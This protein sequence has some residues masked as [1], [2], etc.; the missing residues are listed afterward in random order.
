MIEEPWYE[1]V[2]DLD[3][4]RRRVSFS[5]AKAA[6]LNDVALAVSDLTT[7]GEAKPLLDLLYVI[8]ALVG[9]YDFAFTCDP[10]DF[11]PTLTIGGDDRTATVIM[12]PGSVVWET[13][14]TPDAMLA[15]AAELRAAAVETASALAERMKRMTSS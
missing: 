9:S 2:Q 5:A 6:H 15:L 8:S 10:V 12:R 4:R 3:E 11:M 14:E 1:A 13:K 7:D